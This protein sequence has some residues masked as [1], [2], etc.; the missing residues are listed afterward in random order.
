MEPL[1]LAR[2][3]MDSGSLLLELDMFIF[4]LIVLV[5]DCFDLSPPLLIHILPMV[6]PLSVATPTQSQKD[7]RHPT[8]KHGATRPVSYTHLRAHETPEHLVCRLLLEK[9]KQK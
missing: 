5:I 2:R 6:Q 9:K 4:V 1:S 3:R 7:V 8:H